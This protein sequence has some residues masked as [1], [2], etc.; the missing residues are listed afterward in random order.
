MA[1]A[2]LRTD[3]PAAAVIAVTLG[4]AGLCLFGDV[5]V[6]WTF[7]AASVLIYYAV[8]NVAALRLSRK[9]R[10]FP[11]WLSGVGLGGCIGLAAFVPRACWLWM[12]LAMAADFA[13]RQMLR[14]SAAP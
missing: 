9:Q 5:R 4:I 3:Q 2:A 13:L 14:F 10:L 11:R 6:A 1:L 8:T 7:S 12:V